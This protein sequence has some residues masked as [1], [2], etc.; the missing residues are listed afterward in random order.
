[1]IDAA[2]NDLIRPALYESYHHIVA[3]KDKASRKNDDTTGQVKKVDVVGPICE[4]GDTFCRDR[5]LPI[6]L[7]SGD[8]LAIL[9]SGA[10]GF[11]MTSQ[12]NSRTRASEVLVENSHFR[13]IRNRETFEDLIRGE[14]L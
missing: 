13:I 12:Y 7:E 10:Y 2:M 3:V 1:M 5:E 14:A 11:S 6:D 8:L 9:S 4:T